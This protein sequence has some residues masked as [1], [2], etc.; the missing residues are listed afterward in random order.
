RMMAHGGHRPVPP[1]H[2]R[3]PSLGQMEHAIRQQIRFFAPHTVIL[4]AEVFAHFAAHSED[5]IRRLHDLFAGADFTIV[6]T[7]RRIDDYLASWHGQ[8]FKF[9]HKVAPLRDDGLD[10]YL[11][12][13]HFDYRLM[14]EG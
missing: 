10:D 1:G 9:G 5:L 11:S 14:I 8:R 2:D 4:A 6:A 3:L 13:I 12:G 7:L